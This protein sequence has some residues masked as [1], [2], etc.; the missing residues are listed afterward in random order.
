MYHSTS[1]LLQPTHLH[2]RAHG[3]GV[4]RPHTPTHTDCHLLPQTLQV[5]GGGNGVLQHPEV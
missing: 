4:S 1:D 3:D 2:E 5:P